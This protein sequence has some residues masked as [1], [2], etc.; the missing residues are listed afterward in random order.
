MKAFADTFINI[1][2]IFLDSAAEWFF[3]CVISIFI[4][5]MVL[6][7]IFFYIPKLVSLSRSGE[8]YYRSILL[9]SLEA[10]LWAGII[11]GIYFYLY[12]FQHHL[13][14]AA[15]TGY[16]ALVAWAIT[17]IYIIRRFMNFDRTVK[18]NFYYE[19]YMRY[20]KPEAYSDY[21]N[22]IESLDNLELDEIKYLA[23]EPLRYMHKQ[24]A[25]RKLKEATMN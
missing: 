1:L 23:D 22:F 4:L 6:D 5:P 25:L 18:R 11:L 15:T 2:S 24:A 7:R 10:I 20:I 13:F 17:I 21:L 3:C 12:I 9:T 8:V 16:P 19:I 14:V